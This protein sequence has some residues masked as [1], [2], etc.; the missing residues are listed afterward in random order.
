MPVTETK[1]DYYEVL[2]VD[3]S[4]TRDEIKRAYRQLALK[5]HPD[6]NKSPDAAER[7]REIAEAYAVLSDDAKRREYD[8]SGHAGIRERWT[9][10]DLMREFHFGDFFGGR[11]DDLSEIFGDFW[12]RRAH[13]GPGATRGLDLR[14]DLDLTLEEA[15]KGGEWEIEVTRS[16]TCTS[17]GGSGAQ[18]GTKPKPCRECGGTG[19]KQQ[20]RTS[21]GMRMVTLTTCS[22]C[23][24]RGHTIESPCQ[25]CQGSGVRFVAHTLKVRIPPGVDD[26]TVIRLAGQGE[27]NADGGP[28]GDLLIRLHL[29]SHPVFERHGD[30]LYTI[31][32][33]TFPEAALGTKIPLTGLGGESIHLLVPAGTQSGTALRLSGKGMPKLGGKGKGDLFVVVE[34]KTPTELTLRQREL[35]EEF[36]KLEKEKR[37]Q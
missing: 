34:V 13:P 26:G 27:A 14:Y 4:A 12:G 30:D 29:Q 17:C 22:V 35:L 10:E 8:A 24:G 18:P 1:R 15:A 19:Q 36:A 9:P 6:R 33:I 28:P 31:K 7:F 3:R 5:Y 25:T 21:K 16:E 23:H 11:F 20:V 32:T 2:G 37:R